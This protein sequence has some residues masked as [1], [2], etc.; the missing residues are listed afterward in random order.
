V[1][2]VVKEYDEEMNEISVVGIYES[3]HPHGIPL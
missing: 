1:G 2:E 3:W